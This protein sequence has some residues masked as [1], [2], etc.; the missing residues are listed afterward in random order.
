MYSWWKSSSF[1]L[2]KISWPDGL[3]FNNQLKW[4]EI[5]YLWKPL[6]FFLYSP[7]LMAN[8]SSDSLVCNIKCSGKNV[9]FLKDLRLNVWSRISL[10]W[11][12]SMIIVPSSF[13]CFCNSLRI[14][15][16]SLRCSKTWFNVIKSN[17]SSFN[18]NNLFTHWIPI[19]F[20]Y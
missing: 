3:P 7:L 15:T 5:G 1:R 19:F 18:S 11:G 16:G 8:I 6:I 12:T 17:L 13:K 2:L 4:F 10:A 20:R 9:K 14:L